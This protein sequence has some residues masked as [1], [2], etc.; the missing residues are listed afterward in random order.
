MR[1][2]AIL[3]IV[4]VCAPAGVAAGASHQPALRMS[5]SGDLTTLGLKQIAIGKFGC[6]VPTSLLPSAGRFVIGDPVKLTCLGGKLESVKYFPEKPTAQTS[7]PSQAAQTPTPKGTAGAPS[8]GPGSFSISFGSITLGGGGTTI[9][10]GTTIVS[11]TGPVG[12]I[13]DS[14]ITVQDLTCS[15]NS[16]LLST[17]LSHLSLD[18][19][20][21]N[22]TM[23][24]LSTGPIMSL[25]SAG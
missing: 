5:V 18:L 24:C 13:G 8:S 15:V 22:V 21:T 23:T 11:R 6:A 14:S 25:S 2:L 3:A 1:S 10:A 12:A 4:A 9:P 16:V 17:L 7:V 19:V 20:G